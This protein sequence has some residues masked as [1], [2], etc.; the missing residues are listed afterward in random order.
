[1]IS[2]LIRTLY[3]DESEFA[4]II[5]KSYYFSGT[6][7]QPGQPLRERYVFDY[8][9][10][11]IT[12]SDGSMIIG[13]KSYSLK[14]GDL[15]FRRPGQYTQ[16]IMRYSCFALFFDVKGIMKKNP[17][18]YDMHEEQEY[19]PLYTHPILESIPVLTHSTPEQN[20]QSL[21]SE[22]LNEYINP[23]QGSVIR[24]RSLV[25]D[26]LLK[27]YENANSPVNALKTLA[28]PHY[29]P[30]K[31]V[32]EHIEHHTDKKL[33][34]NELAHVAGLSPNYFHA[35]FTK[36]LGATPNTYVTE[37][38]ICRAKELL[39][40][41]DLTV[42]EISERCGFENIPYFSYLFG[43]KTGVA[44]SEFRRKHSPKL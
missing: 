30:I 2:P 17:H 11:L 34:L 6:N 27:L 19:Q 16:G 20:Y 38:K 35:V 28:G 14:K 12:E 29:H 10:E 15:V 26:L 5:L 44:P 24:L 8:E 13:D 31:K 40:G 39:A 4:P 3:I 7:Y 21:F 25:L 43:K 32:L 18:A 23:K 42:S 1:M 36:A 33:D 9:L 37:L 41:T 22:I